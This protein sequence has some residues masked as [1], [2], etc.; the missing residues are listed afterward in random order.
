MA[1]APRLD[2]HS[3]PARRW[4]ARDAVRARPTRSTTSTRTCRATSR[5]SWTATAAGPARRGM[6]EAEGHA[7]GVEAIRPIVEPRRPPRHRG[8]SRS[9][10]SAART[11]RARTTRSRRS[12]ACSSTA[13]R[14]ET[15]ELRRAGRP[16]PPPRPPRGAARRRPAHRSRTRSAATA[17]GDR[18]TLNVAFNY[19]GRHGDRGCRPA[20]R[21]RRADAPTQI[22][23]DAIDARLYTAG[24]PPLD[25]LIRTGGE[26][27]ISNFLIWQAAVRRAVLHATCS[28]PTS[29]RPRFDAA[30]ARVRPPPPSVRALAAA[31]DAAMRQRA[32]TRRRPRP[33]PAHRPARRRAAARRRHRRGHGARGGRGRS[34]C[35]A[36]PAIRPSRCSG[37][38]SRSWSSSTRRSRPCPGAGR[39]SSRSGSCSSRVAAFSKIDPREG[40]T[41]WMATVVRRAVR[42]AA[43]VRPPPRRCGARRCRPSAPIAGLGAERAWILLLI[44]SSGP[45]TP[46]RTSSGSDFGRAKFLTH[47]SPSQDLRRADRRDRGHDRGRGAGPVGRRPSARSTAW[48]SARSPRCRRRPATSPSRCSSARPGPRTPARSSRAMAGC[49]TASIRSCSRR[50]S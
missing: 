17:G 40:L 2:P 27:R 32:I 38:R 28:G 25:L 12:S 22:D 41:T 34:G 47:I 18:L 30:L 13:I 26:Q 33:G 14:D 50:R 44:L 48:C 31:G 46:A 1:R 10:R 8:R 24:L 4:P 9:S 20:L 3:T 39:C 7:A 19:S 37:R 16:R 5:S 23:E 21:R 49:S 6:A 36:A 42:R 11:G 29:G 43:L 15:P 45:T 35:C